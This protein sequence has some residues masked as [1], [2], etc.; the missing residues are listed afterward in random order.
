MPED[1]LQVANLVYMLV[2]PS[3][4]DIAS[5][6]VWAENNEAKLIQD[7]ALS[8]T[9][10]VKWAKRKYLRHG[11]KTLAKDM[12]I[13]CN[14]VRVFSQDAANLRIRRLT[15]NFELKN[16]TPQDADILSQ[17]CADLEEGA[18]VVNVRGNSYEFQSD[19][20]VLFTNGSESL[21]RKL[22]VKC[23]VVIDYEG[24]DKEA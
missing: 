19:T 2:T 21:K 14:I 5:H 7:P 17:F 8:G 10:E 18:R 11:M 24:E 15:T 12:N 3:D 20:P 13:G 6:N 9:W 22:G 23:D 4:D 1:T 16:A